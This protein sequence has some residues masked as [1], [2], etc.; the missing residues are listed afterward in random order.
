MILLGNSEHE[1]T[2]RK[3]ERTL[4][5]L[6][7][8]AGIFCLLPILAC[9]QDIW[10]GV[11]VYE[12][13]RLQDM[14]ILKKWFL[15][16]RW[17]LQYYLYLLLGLL[18]DWTGISYK[19]FANILAAASVVGVCAEVRR[20]LREELGIAEEYALLAVLVILVFPPWATLM[21]SV[22]A[23]HI[24]CVWAFLLAVR[25]RA[26]HPV[27]A[28]PL[29][30]YSLSLNSI[31]SFTVGYAVFC[32]IM[33]VDRA[34]FK[35]ATGRVF[36][37]SFILLTAFVLYRHFFP[38]Y[39]VYAGYNHFT[40]RISAFLN[41]FGIAVGTLGISY[42]LFGKK[43]DAEARV[44]LFR[45]VVAC[46]ALLFF[47]GLAYWAVGKPVKV[48]GTNSFTPR[49]AYLTAIPMAMLLA[50]MMQY[51]VQRLGRKIPYGIIGAVLLLSFFY[52]FAAYQQKYAQLYYE[53]A[54]IATL[55]TTPP[56]APG[57]VYIS[58]ERKE[59]PKYLRDIA[60]ASNWHFL[61]AYGKKFW[62]AAF[63]TDGHNCDLPSSYRNGTLKY[64]VDRELV[65]VSD[66]RV[67]RMNYSVENF[68]PFGNPLY[69]GYYFLKDYE[70][71]HPQLELVSVSKF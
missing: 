32:W 12:A 42:F 43:L 19:I 53:N 31:F 10:D 45:Q 47:A 68:D 70:R 21:S 30:V 2:S 18:Q 9:Y 1:V 25:F 13:F 44:L 71:L 50:T 58:S 23:F 35:R 37:F 69:Y 27:L 57:F 22:L 7:G 67:T 5:Y 14:D 17:T 8:V 33:M 4:K 49:H 59:T 40:P 56:P 41:Y 3:N 29:F 39:G 15:E 38:P 11:H 52:Q 62:G 54:L 66:L 6:I 26:I 65:S 34:C 24:S 48:E 36:A 51:G 64:A 63:C 55:K 60:A 16:S 61:E 46:L 28:I 20:L